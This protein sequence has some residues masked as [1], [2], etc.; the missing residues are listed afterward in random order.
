[1]T[2]YISREA[3]MN[4]PPLPKEYRGFTTMNLDD[5]YE[6]GWDDALQ[7]LKDLPAADVRPVV[8]GKNITENNPA[9]EFLC[10]KCGIIIQDWSMVEMDW[11]VGELTNHEYVF[12]FCPNCG[13]DMREEAEENAPTIIPAEG[14]EE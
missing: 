12:R 9:D 6:L 11:D 13:A 14:K 8:R 2:D 7:N 10:S 4:V 3:A 5:A 1:M